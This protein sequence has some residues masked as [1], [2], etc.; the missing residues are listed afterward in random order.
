MDILTFSRGNLRLDWDVLSAKNI[1]QCE[2]FTVNLTT[3]D[4]NA[5]VIIWELLFYNKCKV[6]CLTSTAFSLPTHVLLLLKSVQP[7][8]TV[9]L[10]SRL[11]T[12]SFCIFIFVSFP[13][14]HLTA[15]QINVHI[16]IY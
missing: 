8:L 1:W 10:Q 11:S 6:T 3:D 4:K 15:W 2:D 12:N 16:N 14:L 5:G 13:F 9:S 7:T